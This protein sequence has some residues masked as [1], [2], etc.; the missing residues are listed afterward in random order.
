MLTSYVYGP[1]D[2]L[3]EEAQVVPD[4]VLPGQVSRLGIEGV[5]VHDV[6][7]EGEGPVFSNM[8]FSS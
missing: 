3:W 6:L 7:N 2:K 8:I 5:L 4:G 1:F